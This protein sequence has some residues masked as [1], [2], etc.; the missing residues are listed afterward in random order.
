MPGF[1]NNDILSIHPDLNSDVLLDGLNRLEKLGLIKELPALNEDRFRIS[2]D[3]L[4]NLLGVAWT[5]H[6]DG[7]FDRLID[8]W[9]F[10]EQPTEDE[11][12][13]MKI[14]L[15]NDEAKR[16]FRMVDL[17]RLKFNVFRRKCKSA[18]D[19]HDYIIW[20]WTPKVATPAIPAVSNRFQ[21]PMV[22]A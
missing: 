21:C 8:K 3:S 14:L 11:V 13:R 15:G 12:R 5:I 22:K 10:F 2:D 19:L 7:E 4:R 6:R 9:S 17:K 1:S 16:I 20:E 18:K